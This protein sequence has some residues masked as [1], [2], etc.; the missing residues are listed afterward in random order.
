MFKGITLLVSN[1][2]KQINYLNIAFESLKTQGSLARNW[3]SFD[4]SC[5]TAHN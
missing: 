2:L 4:A 5:A 3:A 1:F